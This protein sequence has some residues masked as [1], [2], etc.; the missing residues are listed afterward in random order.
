MTVLD[1]RTGKELRR[2]PVQRE[3]V[4]AALTRNGPV[5]AGGQSASLRQGGCGLRGRR[6]ECH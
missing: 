6:G 2:I 3:P 5:L 1:P 4:A